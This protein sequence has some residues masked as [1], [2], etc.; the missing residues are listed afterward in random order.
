RGVFS[1]GLREVG[2][3]AAASVD[4]PRDLLH[5]LAGL[6]ALGQLLRDRGDQIDLAVDGRAE[7]D[8]TGRNALAERVNDRAQTLC[9]EPIET[10][11]DDRHA[12]DVF[13]RRDQLEGAPLREPGLELSELFLE[14]LLFVEQLLKPAWQVERRDLQQARRLTQRRFLLAHVTE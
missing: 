14:L 2:S 7:A 6:E 3:A 13:R 10:R 1:A 9:V 12:G 11:S 4:Q 5:Q 8:H